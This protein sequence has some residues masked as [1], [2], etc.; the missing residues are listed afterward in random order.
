MATYVPC[1]IT[2]PRPQASMDSGYQAPPSAWVVMRSCRSAAA[3]AASSSV[4]HYMNTISLTTEL[5]MG[6]LATNCFAAISLRPG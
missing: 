5:I 1:W 3:R 2:I 4:S 6:I